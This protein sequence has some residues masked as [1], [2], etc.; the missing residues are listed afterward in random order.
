MRRLEQ[1][2]VQRIG[3]SSQSYMRYLTNWGIDL[4]RRGMVK[5]AHA[6]LQNAKLLGE[7]IF[8]AHHA[9]NA[10]V[11]A[12]LLLTTSALG[13]TDEYAATLLL[14]DELCCR[15]VAMTNNSDI[16]ALLAAA[17]I[18][19]KSKNYSNVRTFLEQALRLS[20]A[21]GDDDHNRATILQMLL[22]L[23]LRLN[24]P[25]IALDYCRLY[26]H[27]LQNNHELTSIKLWL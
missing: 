26:L 21:L 16:S 9:K 3:T 7:G 15:A 18:S 6:S 27:W 1:I 4:L 23:H 24:E 8:G 14:A 20:L 22:V 17:R 19:E 2:I 11:N 12:N 10:T 5:A 25:E 13:L